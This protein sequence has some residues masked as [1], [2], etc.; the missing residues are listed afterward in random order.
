MNKC[1][2]FL[3]LGLIGIM[4]FNALAATNLSQ[5]SQDAY[6]QKLQHQIVKMQDAN[7]I[8]AK[9]GIGFK[10]VSEKKVTDERLQAE[11]LLN[12]VDSTCNVEIHVT[13]D[14]K[15]GFSGSTENR[16]YFKSVTEAENQ[17]QENLRTEYIVMHE[18]SHCRM[19]E[20]KDV[21]K[22]GNNKVDTLL[23]QYF[24]FSSSSFN[25]SEKG[26]A[27]LYYM[28][29]E[30]FADTNAFIQM[31]K[32][33]GPTP[34]LLKTIQKVQIER[35]E[36]TTLHNEKGMAVHNTDYALK[37][38]LKAE[39]LEKVMSTSSPQALQDLALQIANKGLWQS[40]ANNPS[41]SNVL[42]LESMENGTASLV[43]QLIRKDF[44]ASSDEANISINFEGNQLLDTA[45]I[46]LSQIKETSPLYSSIKDEASMG[47]FYKA[48]GDN[49][50]SLI[51]TVI[52]SKLSQSYDSGTD[53]LKTIYNQIK[54]VAPIQVSSMQEIKEQGLKDLN[55]VDVLIAKLNSPSPVFASNVEP[56]PNT[57]VTFAPLFSKIQSVRAAVQN[58]QEFPQAFKSP[59]MK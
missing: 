15:V 21:F 27:S 26:D 4:S 13:P 5:A 45:K 55:A 24:K 6:A 34:D 23:N 30:N 57:G 7:T 53:I 44:N 9:I 52:D 54:T 42:N 2:K 17:T 16:D 36:A 28:L 10:F 32:E 46:V 8:P 47:E 20:I 51:Q 39:N 59:G 31:I 3:L 49:I 41:V 37:E 19:Y 22:T 35:K 11:A 1:S 25:N 48:E 14:M 38:L 18:S 33:H 58:T 50:T 56:T 40:V 29:H 12:I 43:A